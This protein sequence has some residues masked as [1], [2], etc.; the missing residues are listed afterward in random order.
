[1]EEYGAAKNTFR[2]GKRLMN[3]DHVL[4]IVKKHTGR[5]RI[6]TILEEIQKKYSYLPEDALRVVSEATGRPW[7]ISTAWPPST[8]SSA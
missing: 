1:M 4:D 5:G 6:I 8:N 7:W 3:P 2:Q